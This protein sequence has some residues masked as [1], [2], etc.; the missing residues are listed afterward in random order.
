M[1]LEHPG[2]DLQ[3]HLA[4]IFGKRRR[5]QLDPFVEHKR[6]FGQELLVVERPH[7]RRHRILAWLDVHGVGRQR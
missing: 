6:R 1:A 7:H 5:H 3:R 2:V 4:R